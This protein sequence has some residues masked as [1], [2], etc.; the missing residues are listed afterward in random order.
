MKCTFNELGSRNPFAP[1]LVDWLG[2]MTLSFAVISTASNAD[3]KIYDAR[4]S[5]RAVFVEPS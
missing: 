2:R 1:W 4:W 3:P 5:W